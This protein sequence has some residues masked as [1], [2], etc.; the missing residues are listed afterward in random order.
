LI[1][2]IEFQNVYTR[3]GSVDVLQ[4]VSCHCP[5]GA[6]TALIGPS[7]SGKS[8]LLRHV[9]LL[10]HPD[11]GTV[12]IGGRPVDPRNRRATTALRRRI[13]YSVQGSALFPHM[14]V[15]A[16]ITLLSRYERKPDQGPEQIAARVETLLQMMR[17][18]EEYLDRYPHELSGGEQQRVGLCRAMFLGPEILLLDEP[19][20]ALDPVTRREIHEEFQAL[21]A[22]E[23]VT[24]LLVTHDL[25]EAL[26]LAEHVL[27]LNEG[28]LEQA[29]PPRAILEEPASRFV[30]E[31]IQS[32]LEARS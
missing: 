14:T 3:L 2:A 26:A 32:Q 17:L 7:G 10:V 21:R 13:G 30:R 23:P 5:A 29:A 22:A 15:R 11:R 20:G 1:P 25:G 31:F 12:R 19:F 24:A 8:T 9:N 27:I 18:P 6:V 4:D 16:N 28:R